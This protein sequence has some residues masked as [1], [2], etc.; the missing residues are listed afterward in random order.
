ML[1]EDSIQEF[2]LELDIKGVSKE[3]IRS[4]TNSLKIFKEYMRDSTKLDNIEAIHIKE[5]VKFNKDRGLKQKTQNGY[6]SSIRALYTYLVNEEIAPKNLGF[7]V[8]LVNES[9]KITELRSQNSLLTEML[10][11]LMSDRTTIV[12]NTINLDG[13]AVAKGT[14]K[15]MDNEIL[16]LQKR[17]TRLGGAY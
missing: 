12:E 4:Y 7:A 9:D 15:Y 6:I 3:T 16:I 17:R 13:R 14:V 8:K 2:L 5:F 10:G 11:V 1:L